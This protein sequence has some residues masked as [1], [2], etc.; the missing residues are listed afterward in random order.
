[1]FFTFHGSKSA[2][3]F[4]T[5]CKAGLSK[6]CQFLP[7]E[8]AWH[9]RAENA[10]ALSRKPADPQPRLILANERRVMTIFEIYGV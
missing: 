10:K 6:A 7:C 1:M 9:E 5:I 3:T 8:T 4:C 2:A